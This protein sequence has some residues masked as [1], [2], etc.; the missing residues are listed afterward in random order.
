MS[1]GRNASRQHHIPPGNVSIFRRSSAIAQQSSFFKPCRSLTVFFFRNIK[2]DR[3]LER[4]FPQPI[5]L[6]VS[7]RSCA[8]DNLRNTRNNEIAVVRGNEEG[9]DGKTI[10]ILRLTRQLPPTH[11]CG[12]N[13][14]TSQ[15]LRGF[16]DVSPRGFPSDQVYDN[17]S[18]RYDSFNVPRQHTCYFCP[19]SWGRGAGKKSQN[20]T[21][22]WRQ[23]YTIPP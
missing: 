10:R 20:P 21:L 22:L 17:R 9:R 11:G 3:N 5:S 15:T 19:L 6:E 7:F 16:R 8:T 1:R 2:P 18:Q 14:T 13:R 12:R 23:T 4:R